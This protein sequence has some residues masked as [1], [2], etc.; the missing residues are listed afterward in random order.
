[1]DLDTYT[2][3]LR[4]AEERI[5]NRRSALV[6]HLTN[7]EI[8]IDGRSIAREA[9]MIAYDEGIVR[10]A[11]MMISALKRELSAGE[12]KTS[13]LDILARGADDNWS[14]RGND[15]RRSYHDGV[16]DMVNA[17]LWDLPRT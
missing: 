17:V 12:I 6:E 14:G 16:L 1:M 13:L 5:R 4:D 10:I 9:N 7:P 11:S 15:V 8:A 2:D 3:H